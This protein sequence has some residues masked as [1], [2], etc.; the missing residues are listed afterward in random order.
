MKNMKS[1]YSKPFLTIVRC[2]AVIFTTLIALYIACLCYHMIDKHTTKRL[3]TAICFLITSGFLIIIIKHPERFDL[4]VPPL[5]YFC[6]FNCFGDPGIEYPI[7]EFAISIALLWS[8]GFFSHQKT[9]KIILLSIFL[10]GI[11]LSKLTFGLKMFYFQLFNGFQFSILVSALIFFIYLHMKNQP[12]KDAVLNIAD[13]EGTTSRD[14][15][16][17]KLIQQG[18]KY[19]AI[20]IDYELTLGTVQ[21]RL[22]KLYHI[23]E[24]GDRIGFLSMY[25]TAKII[26]K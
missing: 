10:T 17:L 24:T 9:I 19:E 5:L 14:A 12:V 7:I 11:F 22:N 8:R 6:I 25:S 16:W 26:Y 4:F 23:M 15:E 21:N 1:F 18:V 2:L 3:F 20:A 13:F